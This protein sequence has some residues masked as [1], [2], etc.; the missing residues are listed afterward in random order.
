MP[1][2]LACVLWLAAALP[3]FA[4]GLPEAP[5]LRHFGVAEGL[6]SL[7]VYAVA[8]DR[9]G[10]LW[11]ATGDGLARY[12]GVDFRVW[13]HVPGDPASLPG[14]VVQAL[15]V[16]AQ[17][18]VW[19]GT[20]GGGLS[21]LDADRRG[22][23]HFR[24]QTHPDIGS[25]DVWAIASTPDG[26]LWFG[27][28]GGGLHRMDGDGAIVRFAHR[29]DDPASLPA[30][31]VLA[32]AVTP[33]GALWAGTTA[34]AA[35]WNGQG[36]DIVPAA[37]LDGPVVYS[38]SPAPDGGLW[39]G[40]NGG[41]RLRH[42]D[43]RLEAPGW[44]DRLADRAVLAV[45]TD[46][47]GARWLATQ[48]GLDRE[49]DGEVAHLAEGASLLGAW[50]DHEG[51][52]WFASN[53][54][55]LY[56]LP[57]RW[58]DFAVLPRPGDVGAP[59]L[60]MVRGVAAGADG[61]Y[62]LAGAGGLGRL[63]L[64]SGR[65]E[66]VLD[67]RGGLPDRRLW[68]VLERAD[69]SVWI[70]HQRGLSRFGPASRRLA[71]WL[72]EAAADA[73]PP[74]PVDL[75]VEDGQ[76]RLWLS[77]Y[78][79]GVQARDADGRVL[80]DLRPGDG[81]GLA[82]ADTEQ[83]AVGPDGRLWLAGAQGLLAWN[84]DSG[85]FVPVPGAPVERV[86]AFAREG[87]RLW[88]HRLG[89]LEAYDWRDGELHAG[90]RVDARGGLPAVESGGLVLGEGVVW[91]TTPRG[92][93]RYLPANASL[94][95]FGV[96]AGLRSQE[97]ST[98]PP[99]RGRDGIGIVGTMDG[100]VLFAADGGRR[101][102]VAPR[103]ALE[104]SSVRRGD[105]VHVFDAAAP[106]RLGPHDRDL[107]VVARLLS[108]A[109]P[110]SHR[111]R[112]RLRGYDAGWVE[113]G[114]GGE[115]VFSRLDP[116]DY[117]LE[118]QA[119]DADGVPSLPR[120][121]AFA[122]APP[123]WR[124]PWA[125]AAYALLALAGMWLAARLYRARLARRHRY[126]LARERQQLAEQASEAK[127][128]F[129]ATLGHE[130]RTPMT[131]V[132]GMAELLQGTAMDPRQRGY[133][134]AIRHA[135]EH[136]L[137]LVNDTLDL[138][139]IEAGKLGLDDAPFD[140]HALIDEVTALLAPLAGKKG[141]HFAC[142]IAAGTPRGL[143][144]DAHRVRQILL[145]LGNNAIKFT[146]QGSVRLL[147]EPLSPQGV[148]LS[149]I[150]TGPGLNAEQRARLFRRFEQAEGA[151]TAARYGGSGLGLAICQ[152]L[153]A[154][155]GGRIDVESVPGEG[156]RFRVELPLPPAAPA[157]TGGRDGARAAG[158]AGKR[159][160]LVEDDPTIAQVM[161]GLLQAQGHHVSHVAHGLAALAELAHGFDLGLLDLDLP[162]IDGHELARLI[163]AQGH[164]FPLV[165][166]TARAD[167]EAEAQSR[168]AGMDGFLR[169]P[170]TGE[171]LAE[172]IAR[173]LDGAPPAGIAT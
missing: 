66:G 70:G 43:G 140:L 124:T 85:M 142:H 137:R 5:R 98:R 23:R 54:R 31:T 4:A 129:L 40:S 52:Q 29:G 123:W 128:R 41:L 78:G 88:L 167:A 15:H 39:I 94:R 106:I 10:Y 159:I 168:A 62:W 38:L 135:G 34:G 77:A 49:R 131:G 2:L 169:K 83:L 103:L 99:F 17:D 12:D 139:R 111:Y 155:M 156:S 73:P 27:T 47:D 100:L 3:A 19:V 89:V 72:G 157:E 162:G 141:L 117:R 7:V 48:R 75:L 132:L 76:G 153:A 166:V 120:T 112:F 92:L 149:V 57:P 58:Q 59:A 134:D 146:D 90:H 1:R 152:E 80:F 147:A 8:Q 172:V 110:A 115:R 170:L 71:H 46:G 116:G 95:V 13:Q 165:A 53:G 25:D 107:R 28:F 55:G 51:G 171:M 45:L 127:T 150:D 60:A 96:R 125:W 81:R 11:V 86:F 74:G 122:V 93:V 160:L 163:R 102:R 18:R 44:R 50:V 65:I 67:E 119:I 56:H 164:R 82:A 63:D 151:R 121:L 105:G 148:R 37:A 9:E 87:S 64:A 130:V 114:A 143:R 22:F 154:A 20:E 36:F 30:D 26:A 109:D 104:E 33:D 136:L 32:L 118:V 24:R 21:V 16:D 144:G 68:S 6:P 158:G 69:G 61:G 101:D 113:A 79:G 42:P 14:N 108:F 138:A 133:V 91:L 35:R 173:A 145:N 84:D 126:Q 161:V 97:F